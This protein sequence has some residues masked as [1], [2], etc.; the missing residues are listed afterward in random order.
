[1]SEQGTTTGTE[2]GERRAPTPLKKPLIGVRRA[3]NSLAWAVGLTLAMIISTGLAQWL[4]W[5]GV[6]LVLAT[7][8]V[9]ACL[10]GSAWNRAGAAALASFSGFALTLFAGPA[11]YEVYMKTFGDPV[12]AVV[13]EVG[14]RRSG[15]DTDLFCSLRELTGARRAYEVSQMQNCFGQAE[16]GDR[17]VIRQDPL[18]LLEPRL[19]DSADQ[20]GT[21]DLTV[22]I[23]AGLALLTAGTVFYG[24]QRRRNG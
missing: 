22:G 4:V 3:V 15:R 6:V 21:T 16:V 5:L 11:L 10:V 24:G 7:V 14:E 23:S 17:V 1:M 9:A 13:T 19:P 8:A 18:G 12:P 2:L 20:E